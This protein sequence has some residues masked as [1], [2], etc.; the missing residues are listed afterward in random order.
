MTKRSPSKRQ[1]S[2][3]R[4]VVA[5]P[6]SQSSL[7]GKHLSSVLDPIEEK[8]LRMRQGLGDSEDIELETVGQGHPATQAKLREIEL[9]ALKMSGRLKELRSEVGLEASRDKKTKIVRELTQHKE[10]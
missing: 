9:R 2:G 10:R 5:T 6:T 8:A 1:K 4:T 3:V 7:A